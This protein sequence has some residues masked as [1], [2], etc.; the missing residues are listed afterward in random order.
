VQILFKKRGQDKKIDSWRAANFGGE[1]KTW[2]RT[3]GKKKKL[4]PLDCIE[5]ILK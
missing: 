5:F 1:H 4:F 2:C 3:G